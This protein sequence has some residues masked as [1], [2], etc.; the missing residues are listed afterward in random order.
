MFVIIRIWAFALEVNCWLFVFLL[1][2]TLLVGIKL[3]KVGVKRFNFIHTCSK[4][5]DGLVDLNRNMG[6]VF[7]NSI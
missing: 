5:I 2:F 1:F 6:T 7:I 3:E 4:D